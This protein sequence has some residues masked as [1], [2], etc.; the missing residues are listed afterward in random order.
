MSKFFKPKL[1]RLKKLPVIVYPDEGVGYFLSRQDPE[2][3]R[4]HLERLY[5]DNELK[6][7]GKF[8]IDILWKSEG[9]LMT[10]VWMYSQLDNWGSGALVDEKTFRNYDRDISS[11]V[12]A[13]FGLIMLGAEASQRAVARP[14]SK[15]LR[16][17][18]ILPGYITNNKNFNLRRREND[19]TR[20]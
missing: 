6:T 17:R 1:I 15:F 3:I 5:T 13:E 10:D 7:P 2:S 8:N 20:R 16:T 4:R 11:G 14:L 12:S 9:D 19:K 18:P